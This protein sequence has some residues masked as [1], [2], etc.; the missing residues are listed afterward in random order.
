[1]DWE[2]A[3]KTDTGST[4]SGMSKLPKKRKKWPIV[5]AVIVLLALASCISTRIS[6]C[7]KQVA[8]DSKTFTW[9]TSGLGA[10]LPEPESNHG[11]INTDSDTNFDADVRQTN[12]DAFNAYVDACIEKGFD[13]ESTKK[14]TNYTAFNKDGYKLYTYINEDDSEMSISLKAPDELVDIAW[15]TSGLAT[16]LPTPPSTTG[17][18]NS[19]SSESFV[20]HIG[21]MD[22]SA[23][24]A[25]ADSC[26]N[27]GF[28]VDYSR[29]DT[30]Y[31]AKNSDGVELSLQYLGFNEIS[32][33]IDASEATSTAE[34]SQADTDASSSTDNNT[35]SDISGVSA[36]FKETM[37][38][39]EDFMNQ[40]CDFMEK[41]QES[42]DVAAMA[43]DYA[44][45]MKSY[46]EWSEKFDAIDESTLSAAD[47]AYY[48]EVQARVTKR[49]AELS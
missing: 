14:S 30:S 29:Y 35:S 18:I 23:F 9:P 19:D 6:S 47:D 8:E 39:Y 28:N 12:L 41:Y 4:P 16:L 49:L 44:K 21:N 1:M 15:P 2:P 11:E 5:V 33:S 36:D 31:S 45:M 10:M 46:S 43:V 38:G 25:Y 40:Y 48:L 42:D 20:A 22:Q 24:S 34:S 3:G 37:D 7:N 32:I 27:A 17:K 13:I 26:S